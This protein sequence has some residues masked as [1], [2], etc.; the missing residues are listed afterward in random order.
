[1]HQDLQTFSDVM[2]IDPAKKLKVHLILATHGEIDYTLTINDH[3]I[4]ELESVSWVHL[5]DDIDLKIFVNET[6]N[7]AAVE[8]KSLIINEKEVLPL[9][10]YLASNNTSY[11]TQGEWHYYITGPFYTWYHITSGQGWIA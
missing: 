9:Y 4:T 1:M 7:N 5:F 3:Q 6:K 8:V 11:I 2:A 10:Q